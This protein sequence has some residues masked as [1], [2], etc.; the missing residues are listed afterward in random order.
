MIVPMQVP[1]PRSAQVQYVQPA[2]PGFVSVCEREEGRGDTTVCR[3]VTEEEYNKSV[4]EHKKQSDEWWEQYGW[5][6]NIIFFTAIG[7]IIASIV[8]VI[9]TT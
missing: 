1:I 9:V 5:I 3:T 7:M 2:P 6:V 8:V 4:A